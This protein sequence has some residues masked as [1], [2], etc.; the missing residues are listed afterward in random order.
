VSSAGCSGGFFIV[1][2]PS[3]ILGLLCAFAPKR[4]SSYSSPFFRSR[5]LLLDLIAPTRRFSVV[6]V[7]GRIYVLGC[8]G[9]ELSPSDKKKKPKQLKI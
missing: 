7:S 4:L 3:S 1:L 8:Q 2:A 5:K 9:M 6:S